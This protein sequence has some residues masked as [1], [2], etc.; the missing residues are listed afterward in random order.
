MPF[1][2]YLVAVAFLMSNNAQGKQR[3]IRNAMRKIMIGC[4]KR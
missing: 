2:L 1:V 3:E 4:E